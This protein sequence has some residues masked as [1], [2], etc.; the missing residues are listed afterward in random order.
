[1]LLSILV[2]AAMVLVCF[3]PAL[4]LLPDLFNKDNR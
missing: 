2:L 1:M 4:I 3:A